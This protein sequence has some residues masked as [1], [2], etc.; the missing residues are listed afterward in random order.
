VIC[1]SNVLSHSVD[2]PPTMDREP[3]IDLVMQD[4]EV[5]QEEQEEKHPHEY[6]RDLRYP[7]V[8]SWQHDHFGY[9]TAQIV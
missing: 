9:D 4:G 8:S 2:A 1:G 7:A 5:L 3:K 6:M